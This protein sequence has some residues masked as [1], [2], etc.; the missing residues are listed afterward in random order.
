MSNDR[1]G[2][3]QNRTRRPIIFFQ[4]DFLASFENG[5]EIQN[6]IDVG[7]TETVNRLVIVSDSTNI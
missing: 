5:W 6:V 2:S 3:I 7:A 4:A 1:V